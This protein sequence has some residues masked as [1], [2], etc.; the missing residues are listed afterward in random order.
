MSKT[1]ST[2]E[3]TSLTVRPLWSR[4]A[5]KSAKKEAV[6]EAVAAR[7]RSVGKIASRSFVIHSVFSDRSRNLYVLK[8]QIVCKR[9]RE[10]PPPLARRRQKQVSCNLLHALQSTRNSK[11]PERANLK[12]GR[13]W[14]F[15]EHKIQCR[16]SP[17]FTF[18][19]SAAATRHRHPLSVAHKLHG[20]VTRPRKQDQD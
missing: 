2:R 15:G 17:I 11:E 4:K 16:Q 12:R 8:C 19:L 14:P 10:L 7:G 6:S 20:G 5:C 9:L 18:T 3:Q 1:H 13:P